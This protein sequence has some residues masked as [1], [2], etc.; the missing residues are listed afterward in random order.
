MD[1]VYMRDPDFTCVSPAPKGKMPMS[2]LDCEINYKYNLLGVI[3]YCELAQ[4]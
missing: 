4:I 3:M 1:F 2:M